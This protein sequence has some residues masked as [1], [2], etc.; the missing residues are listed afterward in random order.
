MHLHFST[1]CAYCMGWV[2]HQVCP[3]VEGF[4]T[5]KCFAVVQHSQNL[6]MLSQACSWNS[7]GGV[8]KHNTGAAEEFIWCVH[9]T[10]TH[11]GI[12]TIPYRMNFKCAFNYT[13]VYSLLHDY[14]YTHYIDDLIHP[15]CIM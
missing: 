3:Q 13:A 9:I 10:H 11:E 6:K 2:F 5:S 7:L 4:P 14:N 8:T 15:V 12:K 1:N